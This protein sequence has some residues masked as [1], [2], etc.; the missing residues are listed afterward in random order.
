MKN[1][2]L[3][4]LEQKFET[5]SDKVRYFRDRVWVPKGNSLRSTILDEARQSRY[6][7]HLGADKMYRELKECYWW[8]GLNKD[9]TSY[10]S[11]CLTCAKVKAEHQKPSGL[12]QQPEIPQWKWEQII[13]D[14]LTKLPRTGKGYDSI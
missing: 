7:I 2:A 4:C 13:M 9:V 12:L 5:R 14:L 11:K 6:S 8:R 10:V 1:E 3:H